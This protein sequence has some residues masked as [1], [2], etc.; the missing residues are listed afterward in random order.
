MLILSIPDYKTNGLFVDMDPHS[1]APPCY[2][3]GVGAMSEAPVSVQ[4]RLKRSILFWEIELDPSSFVLGIIRSGYRLPFIRFPPSVCMR[5]HQSALE[6]PAFV[7]NAIEELVQ[8]NCVLA[9]DVCPLVCSPLQVVTNARGK[10]RLVIDLRFV[11]QYLVQQKFKYEGLN[12]IPSLFQ[13]GDYMITFD[14]KSGYHHVDINKEFWPY[15]GFSWQYPGG[16]RRFFM[17]RV[18]PFGLSTACYV[19]TKLLRPLVKHWRSNGRQAVIYIDD[20]ICA[21]STLAEMERHSKAIQADLRGAGFVLNTEKSKLVPHQEGEWL[22]CNISLSS[23]CFRVPDEKIDR[24]KNSVWG[25]L[26]PN[27]VHVRSVASIVGQIMSMS[28]A[29]GPI[30]RLRTRALYA[31]INNCT[32]WH[33]YLSL[34]EEA[35][36]ELLFW[37][38]NVVTLNGHPIWFKSGAT[39]VVY[40][41]AVIRDIMVGMVPWSRKLPMVHGL[42]MKPL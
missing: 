6:N 24:L 35:R 28:L 23:G 4:G 9:C 31:I 13:Q 7:S 15:L 37:Q 17:F 16:C 27:R 22:G 40:S 36:E 21:A 14:L 5:N 3:V 32:S 33:A 12:V 41:D 2:E 39:R 8:T 29:L 19:F 30:A 10:Q 18:L 38:S 42:S 20:G 25:I 26:H 34:G 11:N 1:L